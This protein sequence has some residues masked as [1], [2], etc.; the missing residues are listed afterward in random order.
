MRKRRNDIENPINNLHYFTSRWYHVASNRLLTDASFK[1]FGNGRGDWPKL[2]SGNSD[3]Y[4]L[5]N[6]QSIPDD[7]TEPTDP[8]KN[9]GKSTVESSFNWFGCHSGNCVGW[10]DVI[11]AQTTHRNAQLKPRDPTMLSGW[12]GGWVAGRVDTMNRRSGMG[13]G[14]WWEVL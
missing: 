8:S 10:N 6:N 1:S 14:G 12:V 7:V 3:N 4:R 5:V 11:G 9:M 2:K 13:N